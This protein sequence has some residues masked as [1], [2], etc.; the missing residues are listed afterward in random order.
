VNAGGEVNLASRDNDVDALS[1]SAGTVRFAYQDADGLN[2]F[3][4][5]QD[6][7]D[8]LDNAS[9][10]LFSGA[11]GLATA[12]V[13]VTLK[14]LSGNLDISRRIDAGTGTVRLTSAGYIRQDLNPAT[15]G[16]TDAANILA[17]TLGVNAGTDVKLIR[18]DNNVGV[19][20]GT[21][22]GNFAYQDANGVE[23]SEVSPDGDWLDVI[24]PPNIFPIPSPTFDVLFAATDGISTTNS[25]ITLK[26]LDGNLTLS[27]VISAGTGTVRL[28]SAGA[29]T[30]GATAFIQ[31]A[32]LGV[33]AAGSVSLD[34]PSVDT[35]LASGN[36]VGLL[37]VDISGENSNL[38]YY[39]PASANGFD[40]DT[41]TADDDGLFTATTQGLRTRG[42]S[43]M[44][45]GG[46]AATNATGTV[47]LKADVLTGF[48][49][50][51][52]AR[53]GGNITFNAPV[54]VGAVAVN[55]SSR[56]ADTIAVPRSVAADAADGQGTISF[57]S[58]V[59]GVSAGAN[60]LNVLTPIIA[61]EPAVGSVKEIPVDTAKIARIE[62]R[63]DVGS[64]TQLG[65][66]YLNDRSNANG[67]SSADM[68]REALDPTS[69]AQNNTILFGEF[70]TSADARTIA[71]GELVVGRGE[72]VQASGPLSIA[73]NSIILGD[74]GVLGDFRVTTGTTD[75]KLDIQF[76]TRR[77]SRTGGKYVGG[78][79]VVALKTADK[80]T[81]GAV[82]FR[83]S[84][85]DENVPIL[86]FDYGT[87][88]DAN[89]TLRQVAASKF[90]AT[91]VLGDSF[92][93]LLQS[94]ASRSSIFADTRFKLNQSLSTG[95]SRL[96]AEGVSTASIAEILGSASPR[97]AEGMFRTPN[98]EL[99]S[100]TLAA[101][102]A[103]RLAI[104]PR[105]GNSLMPSEAFE[106]GYEFFANTPQLRTVQN[107]DDIRISRERIS[108]DWAK[109]LLGSF[110]G[111]IH[112]KPDGSTP[113]FT[114]DAERAK[115]LWEFLETKGDAYIKDPAAFAASL[116]EGSSNPG[117]AQF[118]T[119]LKGVA[120]LY[121]KC[122]QIGLT[123]AETEGF[124]S[125]C[126]V[127]VF[128][129]YIDS[130]TKECNALIRV[131][132]A[133]GK[134]NQQVAAK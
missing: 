101:L 32:K 90:D 55:V 98:R 9:D 40:V 130:G 108:A 112:K 13:N 113:E 99:S 49:T 95:S 114:P 104:E 26:N 77:T 28:N 134:S 72:V 15:V 20:S 21:S 82:I 97:E 19:V 44:L 7:A 116:N 62:F 120:S 1:G 107:S 115:T 58:T 102:E 81:D 35:D 37:S 31:A 47:V 27:R 43:V 100:A 91:T 34:A 67:A 121:A 5:T 122:D 53:Q 70:G 11:I 18:A 92:V 39:E 105:G 42:G 111:T 41:L 118:V 93:Q 52:R 63:G 56:S 69:R 54:R 22:V 75:G 59:D 10:L 29:V 14:S 133:L 66:L 89:N 48:D 127:E 33:R 4:T 87:G 60:K 12:N 94:D 109:D 86:G 36:K 57:W 125:F 126:I 17:G 6:R 78:V 16:T 74:I 8:A 124:R 83:S 71:A 46:S 103:A 68:H 132:E 131:A 76:R 23:V 106:K 119:A 50:V 38:T 65:G 25:D 73:A 24:P 61:G 30:Q 110:G 128:T 84:V 88:Y 51:N 80:S 45:A 96:T 3:T 117:E 129:G 2:V 123:A 85:G 79:D 64:A